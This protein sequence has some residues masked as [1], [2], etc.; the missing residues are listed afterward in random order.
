V[1]KLVGALSVVTVALGLAACGGTT[2]GHST[3]TT[4]HH[5]YHAPATVAPNPVHTVLVIHSHMPTP[6]P[7]KTKV[8][9]FKR[10]VTKKH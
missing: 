5:V 8:S 2:A 6:A 7:V 4:V 9:L 1:K 3:T 10:I